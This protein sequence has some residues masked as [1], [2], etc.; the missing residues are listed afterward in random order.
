MRFTKDMRRVLV[1]SATAL[2]ITSLAAVMDGSGARGADLRR[3]AAAPL[4]DETPKTSA[5]ETLILAGGCFWGVQGVFQHIR[6]VVEAVSGYDGGAANTAQYETVSTGT[7]GHAESVR[8]T[9]DPHVI[10]YGELLRIFFSVA[11]DP[12]QLNRQY[13]DVGT[14][15]RSEIFA[16]T[17]EQAQIAQAY[18]AQLDRAGAFPR[19]IATKVGHDT[20]F[21]T[22]ES[23]H[24]NYLTLHPDS[25]Y[26]ATFDLPK[27][28]TLRKVFPSEFQSKPVLVRETGS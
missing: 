9:Y 15:Y 28:A 18:I 11:T 27:I 2:V 21:Y 19:S 7:T 24:Q 5:T 4:I 6:G 26:I 3:P 10:S 14:Q 8:I 22:A 17:P 20:G 16:K 23:Y 25:P 12:T 13:P 1:V